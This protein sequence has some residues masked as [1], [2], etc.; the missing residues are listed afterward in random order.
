MHNVDCIVVG[1]GVIGLAAARALALRGREVLVLEAA[2]RFGT[3]ISSRNS[4]VIHAGIYYP[5]HSLKAR[6]CAAGRDRLYAYC[7]KAGVE[8]RRCGKLIV[9]TSDTQIEEL[10]AVQRTAA[11]NGVE[12]QWLSAAAAHELEPVLHCHAALFSPLTGIIDSHEYMMSLLAEAEQQ[13]TT[14]AYAC[15]VARLWPDA[16]GLLLAVNQ[17]TQPSLRARWVINCAGLHAT[18]VACNVQALAP[19]H[20]PRLY[21]ARGHYFSLSGRA[22]FKHLIYPLPVPGGLGVHL[23]LDIAGRA[24]FGP[25]V[26]W[27]DEIDYDVCMTRA[28]SF[29]TAVRHFWPELPEGKLVPAYAGI[30]PNLSGPGAKAVDF[31]IQGPEV[32]GIDGLINLFGIDSP[33]LTASLPLADHIAD[34]IQR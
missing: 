23:T 25:D 4:E 31:M 26:E 9:A 30:R 34:V 2:G 3:G 14:V 20:I 33:G 10:R 24:R 16:R 1:A 8:H 11:R 18:E 22:P 21:L 19:Q 13:G 27:V 7:A 5:E 28:A 17:D 29:Y 6:F 15:R 32:H 12:L